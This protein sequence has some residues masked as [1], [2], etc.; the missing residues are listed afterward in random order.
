MVAGS[1]SLICLEGARVAA[2]AS[3]ITRIANAMLNESPSAPRELQNLLA[4]TEAL[5]PEALREDQREHLGQFL[6]YAHR[7]VPFYRD[8]LVNAARL[9]RDLPWEVFR[10]IPTMTRADIREQGARLRVERVP[11][12][13][14]P[15]AAITT[16]GS[17]GRPIT[18]HTTRAFG[19]LMQAVRMRWHEWHEHDYELST[20]FISD[21]TPPGVADPP[22]GVTTAPWA[23]PYGTGPSFRL[24][25][26][27][28]VADQLAWL[29]HKRPAYLSTYPSNLQA[30]LKL[31]QERGTRLPGL[32]DVIV[33]SEPVS[34]QLRE[35]TRAV[36]GARLIATYSASEVGAIAFQAPRGDQY[37]VQAESVLVEILD[38]A[39]NPCPPGAVGRVVI[40]TLQDALR[41]L[42]RYEVGDYAV[43]GEPDEAEG[44]GLPVLRRI[45][46]RERAMVRLPDG[47]TVWPF[48]ELSEMVALEALSQWQLA[49]RRDHSLEVR[50]VTK[51]PL[52]PDEEALVR[53]VV[54]EAVTAPLPLSI[55]YVEG[56]ERTARGKFVEFVSEFDE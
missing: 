34:D 37:L 55:R 5:S 15:V 45:V 56:I 33:S 21:P 26:R 47:R 28:D 35:L 52:A 44:R 40:T 7:A 31:A 48:F 23:H 54:T 30:L 24:N 53:R 22:E 14:E 3:W 32:R 17:T 12:G 16:S 25:L 2:V 20:A 4:E 11:P 19:R 1:N 36:W 6:R 38:E 49:Q 29:E 8:R 42:V 18:T 13:F 39:D 27:A 41:P 43:A 46:G 10:Q 50:L 51:R 9:G